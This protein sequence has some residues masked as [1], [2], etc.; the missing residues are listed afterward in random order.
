MK[1]VGFALKTNTHLLFCYFYFALPISSR[2]SLFFYTRD[3]VWEILFY[4]YWYFNSSISDS[5]PCW[6][7]EEYFCIQTRDQ[8][9]LS[10]IFALWKGTL[11]S[12]QWNENGSF[13]RSINSKF[14][15]IGD[16]VSDRAPVRA[17]YWYQGVSRFLESLFSNK[18]TSPYWISEWIRRIGLLWGCYKKSEN[19]IAPIFASGLSIEYKV[20]IAVP[21]RTGRFQFYKLYFMYYK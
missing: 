4:S 21:I 9:V 19:T 14:R 13:R 17:L 11:S 15:S 6:N 5:H 8:N 16:T 1:P 3:I 2:K 12:I 10:I 20:E 18:S 7:N